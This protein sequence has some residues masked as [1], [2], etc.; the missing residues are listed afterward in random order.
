MERT[1]SEGL[2]TPEELEPYLG[3]TAVVH[4]D[5]R[6]TEHLCSLLR[7][8][9]DARP[10]ARA[11]MEHDLKCW[12]KYYEYVASGDKTFE[13]RRNDRDFR[14]GDTLLLREYEPR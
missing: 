3:S 14:V 8:F 6:T 7:R 9:R 1:M 5:V 11:P 12:P 2:P 13:V 4:V 10:A